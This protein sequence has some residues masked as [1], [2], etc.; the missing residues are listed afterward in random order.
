MLTCRN[1]EG[2]HVLRKVGN[3]WSKGSLWSCCDMESQSGMC[4][5]LRTVA[6][7]N[8]RDHAPQSLYYCLFAP[9]VCG[10]VLRAH[11]VRGEPHIQRN[12]SR[13]VATTSPPFYNEPHRRLHTE[14]PSHPGHNI[15]LL[16][17]E[18]QSG[19]C[20][21][22]RTVAASNRDYEPQL[23]YYCLFTPLIYG[24]WSS[25]TF[26]SWWIAHSTQCQRRGC[27]SNSRAL[28][29][30]QCSAVVGRHQLF[31]H[32]SRHCEHIQECT[33]HDG[34]KQGI[35]QQIFNRKSIPRKITHPQ[36]WKLQAKLTGEKLKGWSQQ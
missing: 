8:N 29:L 32:H 2:V 30:S 23:L 25:R 16:R 24:C 34:W 9:H 4:A 11:S 20:A 6:A 3:P 21:K 28:Y 10:V 7:S 1:A 13:E 31:I 35:D 14:R 22:L 26:R 5:K 19:M 27:N 12:A 33:F 36:S 18:S 15:I 17:S